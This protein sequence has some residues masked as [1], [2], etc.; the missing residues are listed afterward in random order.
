MVVGDLLVVD[1]APERQLGQALHVGRA[2]RVLLRALADVPGDLLELRDHVARE[3]AARRT[4]VREHRLLV[5]ALRGRERAARGEAVPRGGLAL[6]RREVVEQGRLRALRALGERGDVALAV[7]HALDDRVGVLA[8]QDVR[9]R[10]AHVAAAVGGLVGRL[11]RRVDEPVR[12]RLEGLDLL[13]APHQDRQRRRLHAPERDDRAAERGAAADRRR[14]RGVHAHE[15]VGLG[16]RA[17]GGL[18]RR[19]LGCPAAGGRT[20][21]GSRPSSSTRTTRAAPARPSCR[22]RPA[23]R[24]RSARPRAR[25]RRRSRSARCRRAS[26]AWRSRRAAPWPTCPRRA[27]RRRSAAGGSAGRPS[28]SA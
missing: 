11:E 6:E 21:G 9:L 10:A 8:G 1:D 23:R 7:A 14:A 22:R 24:R 26:S 12:R 27:G 20:P 5:A 13:L 19:E 28:S 18:E 2:L 15:P 17:R 3:V 4:R 25:R 16:A